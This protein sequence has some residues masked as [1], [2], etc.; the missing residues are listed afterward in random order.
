MIDASLPD[1][2][3]SPADLERQAL[4]AAARQTRRSLSS[5]GHGYREHVKFVDAR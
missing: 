4:P 3:C 2:G 1:G 5:L